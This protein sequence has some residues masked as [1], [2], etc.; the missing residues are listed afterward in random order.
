MGLSVNIFKI[1]EIIYE[2]SDE[3]LLETVI[4]HYN[5]LSLMVK[6]KDEEAIS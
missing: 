6:R 2:C 5:T 4:V 1:S 3:P